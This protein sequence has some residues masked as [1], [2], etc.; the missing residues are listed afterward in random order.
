MAVEFS[1][2][3]ERRS[4]KL[5]SLTRYVSKAHFQTWQKLRQMPDFDTMQGIFTPLVA[6]ELEATDVTLNPGDLV[7]ARGESVFARALD[8]RG[9]VRNILRDGAYEIFTPS[10]EPGGRVRFVN[11]FTRYDP[12]PA[13]RKILELPPELGLGPL[14]DRILP[15]PSIEDLLPGDRSPD[16][17]DGEDHVWYYAQTDP[18]RHVNSLA[19]LHTAQEFVATRLHHR[20]EA[21]DRLWAARARICFRKPCF[22]GEGFRR[23]AWQTDPTGPRIGVAIARASDPEGHPPATAIELSLMEHPAD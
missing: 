8:G 21:L 5:A 12:D 10:G 9:E 16:F 13:R 22:R 4:L 20:G 1:D 7:Q 3:S 11:V 14:P 18:N 6:M 19:Y 15:L 2:L 23:L 17:A